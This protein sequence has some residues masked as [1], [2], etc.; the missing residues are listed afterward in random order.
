MI[1]IPLL[2]KK[3]LTAEKL[4]AKFT[5]D[6]PDEKVKQLIDLNATRIS[7]GVDRNLSDARTIYA[8]DQAYDA[9]HRQTT[10]TLVEGL[11]SSGMSGEKVMDAMNTW[12]QGHQL[13][14]MLSPLCKPDGTA[15]CGKDGKPMMKLDL[16]TFF[17]VY[18][19]LVAAYSKI[20]W[21][22]LW[23]D[24]D[25]Y[26]LY[27]YEPTT[28]TTKNRLRCEMVTKRVQRMAQEM[29]YREDERQS[30]WQALKY[31]SCLNFPAEDYYRE[32]Q[33]YLEGGKEVRK[34]VKEGVRWEI[35]HPSRVF[36]D[37]NHRISTANTDTGIEYAGY[38]NVVRYRDVINNK[39]FWNTDNVQ[40][41][42]GN[43]VQNKY[44]IYRELYPCA[45]RFPA[46]GSSSVGTNERD[47]LNEAHKYTHHHLDEGVT[48]VP[49][50]HRLV[51]SEWGLG[52]YDDPIWMR[53]LYAGSHTV[54]HAAPFAYTPVV[55]YLYDYDLLTSRGTSLGL[56]L[57]PFQDHVSN[58]LSQYI[59]T[60]KQ[61]LERTVFWN[62]DLVDQKYVETIRNLGE[63]R[64]RGT[65]FIPYSKRE[66]A[67][68]QQS[69]KDAFSPVVWEKG[70]TQELGNAMMTILG[71]M[72]RIMGYSAQELGAPAAHEQSATE[73][74]VVALN[75]GHRITF[76]GGFIDS[77]MRA[78]KKVLYDAMMA[79]GDDEI[80]GEV[81]DL[82]EERRKSLEELGFQ[83]EEEGG[84]ETNAGVRG[85]KTALRID[86]FSSDRENVNRLPDQK[87]AATM[88]Q[89][90]QAIFA[91]PV[92]AQAAGLKQ[93]IDLFN[94]IL[95][96][97]G[98]PIDFRL[99]VDPKAAEGGSP[100][101]R[102]QQQGQMLQQVQE[103]IAQMTAQMVDGKLMELSDGLRKQLVE[104][105][106]A[107]NQAVEQAI[108]TLAE[109]SATHEEV[110]S[111]ILAVF[112]NAQSIAAPHPG[113]GG[114]LNPAMAGPPPMPPTV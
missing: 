76:T 16:P 53:F 89:T 112:Q 92:L 70:N 90:F 73:V 27:K 111:K 109:K 40:Y 105:Q 34:I 20:R 5:A 86:S 114:G 1:D 101:E 95:V 81:A 94:Q 103:Q 11:L 36:Y 47:R 10:Y 46:M 107:Q 62:A 98:A 71:L 19:P 88:I 39:N 52:D 26:P 110:L 99:K 82:D 23:N 93:L 87:I 12:G 83:I 41:R 21:A 106:A 25:I 96:Y 58:L 97:S 75:A 43:W 57:M 32:H 80:M 31:G 108:T 79:Y 56:E 48:L 74:Q 45:G 50:F 77:G 7:E 42:Y 3:G 55:A 64:Y 67:W 54:I 33:S 63:K 9:A 38:W 24:R 37:M 100:E 14:E 104:P 91:N 72:E 17:H 8:I 35:P 13:R 22:K 59:L 102:E 78:R 61:N 6:N 18:V 60:V 65:T 69:E 113:D 4:K 66:F 68:Q 44:A 85:P 49:F 15:V 29:G 51:P 28:L 2:E 30:I 84:K